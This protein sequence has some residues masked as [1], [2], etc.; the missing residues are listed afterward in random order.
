[1]LQNIQDL[2]CHN[3]ATI[4]FLREKDAKNR[5]MDMGEKHAHVNQFKE[6]R[7]TCLQIALLSISEN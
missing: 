1:M 6:E 5:V 3:T 7:N 2:C 4:T